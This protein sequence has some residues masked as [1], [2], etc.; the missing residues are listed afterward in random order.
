[1]AAGRPPGGRCS[2]APAA[3]SL[4][5]AALSVQRLP[6]PELRG[7]W[8]TERDYSLERIVFEHDEEANA[9]APRTD[10]AS[11]N[12]DLALPVEFNLENMDHFI[13]WSA[14]R[15]FT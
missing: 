10:P 1:V 9:P 11:L 7:D 14:R 6:P 13:D 5:V 2:S 12:G 8:V 15:R 4:G 3:A